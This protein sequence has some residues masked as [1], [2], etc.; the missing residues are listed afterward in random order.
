MLN[1]R[2]G[3][4]KDYIYS[5][6]KVILNELLLRPAMSFNSVQ[7]SKAFSLGN[8]QNKLMRYTQ[9]LLP[10]QLILPGCTQKKIMIGK[11][12]PEFPS[13]HSKIRLFLCNF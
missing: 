6:R 9:S 4:A 8:R 12:N 13:K 7:K 11:P 5:K 2:K 10:T 3:L 1:F